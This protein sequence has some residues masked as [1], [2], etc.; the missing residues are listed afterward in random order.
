MV[1]IVQGGIAVPIEVPEGGG[2]DL[3]Q[4]A[5][6]GPVAAAGGVVRAAPG[7]AA[8]G[9]VDKAGNLRAVRS[10]SGKCITGQNNGPVFQAK[11]R[12]GPYAVELM[13][14]GG[15]SNLGVQNRGIRPG[16]SAVF[17]LHQP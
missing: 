1:G 13:R 6:A 8:V 17:R 16:F 4:G 14:S 7:L 9:G 2:V 5:L 11:P 15:F 10:A 3:D 12:P